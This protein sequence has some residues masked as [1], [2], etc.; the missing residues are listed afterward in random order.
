MQAV[1]LYLRELRDTSKLTQAEAGARIGVESKT[2]ERWEAGKNEPPASR[3]TAYVE[4]LG[5]SL[6]R[7]VELLSDKPVAEQFT[8]SERHRVVLDGLPMEDLDLVIALAERLKRSRE[9]D[10]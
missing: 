10:Q 6:A 3:L 9:V 4:S 1:G 5:G 7:L 8:L 2:V